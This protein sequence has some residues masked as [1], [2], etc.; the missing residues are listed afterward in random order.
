VCPAIERHP[1]KIERGGELE[2]L[3]GKMR[4]CANAGMGEAVF[5][6]IGLDQVTSSLMVL[7]DTEGWTI[8]MFGASAVSVKGAKS[9]LGSYG[10]L[11]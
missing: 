10:T 7:A 2:H 9:L 6:G 3:A 4:R 11:G 8:R 5:A 1:H